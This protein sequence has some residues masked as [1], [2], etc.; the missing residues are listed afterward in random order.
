MGEL[1]SMQPSEGVFARRL[2]G[3]KKLT[4]TL[5]KEAAETSR[6]ASH[7]E[8][9]RSG[10]KTPMSE[11]RQTAVV[12]QREKERQGKRKRK[13]GRTG[14]ES[15]CLKDAEVAGAAVGRGREFSSSSS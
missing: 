9:K 14:G 4:G 7:A 11:S 8:W 6:Q 15:I 2:G 1:R 12:L 5:G 13:E 3:E 10:R